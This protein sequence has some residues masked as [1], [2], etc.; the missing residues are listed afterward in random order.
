[1]ITK[2][3]LKQAGRWLG[4]Y[5]VVGL[6]ALAG[7]GFYGLGLALSG[8][9]LVRYSLGFRQWLMNQ[10]GYIQRL[11][12]LPGLGSPLPATVALA[13]LAYLLPLSALGC[14]FL[15]ASLLLG[16]SDLNTL[17]ALA[18]LGLP[19]IG[20]LYGWFIRGWGLRPATGKINL[21][22]NTAQYFRR[23]KRLDQLKAL[24]PIAFELFVGSLFERMG[25]TVRTTPA[26]GDQGIDLILYKDSRTAI[27]QCKRYEGSVGQ[28]VV[29]DLYGTMVHNRVDEAYLVT[30][31][32]ISLPARQWAN[33]KAI[34]LVDGNELVTWLDSFRQNDLLPDGAGPAL[35]SPAAVAHF[36]QRNGLAGGVLLASLITPL[37]C[38]V[39]SLS[40]ARLTVA[41]LPYLEAQIAWPAPLETAPTAEPAERE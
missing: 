3:M 40:L 26:S 38:C 9:A 36:F 7:L 6:L 15:A 33:G 19:G 17:L 22:Q 1:M 21:R 12:R 37:F 10:P 18:G 14:L 39:M 24:D 35:L 4:L 23:I 28:P 16:L 13:L 27:V 2:Q 32:T 31:G 20:L 11:S 25:Y 29:R 8:A 41:A 5:P 34:H 30:T